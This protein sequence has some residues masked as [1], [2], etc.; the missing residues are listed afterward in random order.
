[1]H[2][3]FFSYLKS[4]FLSFFF[5]GILVYFCAS[6]I[7]MSDWGGTDAASLKKGIDNTFGDKGRIPL[8]D[9]QYKH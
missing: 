9:D 3:Y 6:L 2:R 1:M 5:S 8:K 7:E 4:M